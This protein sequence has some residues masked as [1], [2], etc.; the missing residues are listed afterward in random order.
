MKQIII[1]LTVV[2]LLLCGC[3]KSL[4]PFAVGTTVGWFSAGY[5]Y[6]DMQIYNEGYALGKMVAMEKNS[7]TA[8]ANRYETM[9]DGRFREGF[10][11]GYVEYVD[12]GR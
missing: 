12:R 10:I 3:S 8:F 11:N 4:I 2:C 7:S 9:P 5:F 6:Q 1:C